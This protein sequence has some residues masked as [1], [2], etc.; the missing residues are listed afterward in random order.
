MN[1]GRK[2]VGNHGNGLCGRSSCN[3]IENGRWEGITVDQ[4]YLKVFT[5]A[6]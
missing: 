2:G 6:L 5:S 4:T 1:R 3:G